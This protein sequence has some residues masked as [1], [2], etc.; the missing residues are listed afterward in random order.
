[1]LSPEL[2][3]LRDLGAV[4]DLAD[5]WPVVNITT[6]P[7]EHARLGIA[8]L[9]AF[10]GIYI[11]AGIAALAWLDATLPPMMPIRLV[12]SPEEL[13]TCSAFARVW[14]DRVTTVIV[15]GANVRKDPVPD[16]LARCVHVQSVHIEFYF[17]PVHTYMNAL[18]TQQL[19]TLEIDDG[20]GH[21]A[22]NASGIIA[23]LQGPHATS[24]SLT[25]NSVRD[26]AALATAIYDCSHLTS[27]L[28]DVITDLITSLAILDDGFDAHLNVSLLR[29]LDRTKVVSFSLEKCQGD[30]GDDVV[31]TSVLDALAMC[32]AL[33]TL[34]LTNLDLT[35]ASR[36]AGF[37][38]QLTTVRVRS[39]DF[40]TPRERAALLKWL[41]TS[42]CLT[43]VD[44]SGT[45]LQKEGIVELARALPAWMARGLETLTLQGAVRTTHA[46]A[47]SKMTKR[48]CQRA[49]RLSSLPGVVLHGLLHMLD[50][51]SDVLILLDALPVVTL[52]P[53]LVALR[54]LGAVVALDE[55]WPVVHVTKIPIEHAH[56]GVAA[57]PAFT[58]VH[59]DSGVASLAWL[60]ATP[61]AP[62]TLVADASVPGA[63]SAFAYAWG[64][65]ITKV[66]VKA[67][68]EDEDEN[69]PVPEMLARCSNVQSVEI[70]SD[71]CISPLL[72][73]MPTTHLHTLVVDA[74]GESDVDTSSIVAWLQGPRATSLSFLAN[75]TLDPRTL[76][77]AIHACPTLTS[78]HVNDALDLLHALIALPKTLDN[79]SS[80]SLC[81]MGYEDNNAP[82]ALKVLRKLNPNNVVSFALQHLSG[83]D[84][85]VER[86]PSF[87]NVLATYP[88]LQALDLNDVFLSNVTTTDV[89]AHLSNVTVCCTTFGT[90]NDAVH[91]IRWLS[92][93]RVLRY[94]DLTRTKLGKAGVDA[95][96][97]A[98]PMWMTSGLETLTLSA[99]GL[100]GDDAAL[101]AGALAAGKNRRHFALD[102]SEN[103]P[104]TL[105]SARR[106]MAALGASHNV[107][108]D[109]GACFR[110][111]DG[112]V[113]D[114]F[115]QVEA[116]LRL[117][118]PY[119]VSSG[120]FKA[121][122]PITSLWH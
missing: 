70:Q 107:T 56:L 82:V 55:H 38:P 10:A 12:V 110:R 53:E 34:S 39:T 60:D 115:V 51:D 91:F 111:S 108:L 42:R 41:S 50:D 95:L 5:H 54:D 62:V 52:P 45:A 67:C 65:R 112:A 87:I 23:W 43:S 16:I 89:C 27:S 21:D 113:C 114:Q 14:G 4:V 24:L 66:I 40:D 58:G 13:G 121:P 33:S 81:E 69:D 86:I 94:V 83:A 15:Q 68:D 79:I 63:L 11:D 29:K 49:T 99:A 96:A 46:P 28:G 2:V 57:L 19:H 80:L 92:T 36:T 118:Q 97:Q 101:L 84:L 44:L 109:L 32:P 30:E 100:N 9:P 3:A 71:R 18:S 77:K 85:Q 98:L 74:L 31:T 61:K 64:D 90:S 17:V 93:S 103:Y 75:T 119:E 72:A 88:S 26:P 25:C 104:L 78:L 8:A 76:A 35:A 20:W 6:M 120:V 1:M 117:H 122:S 47:I 37:W 7:I 59:V 73:A 106:L 116:L 102:L 22:V 48:V 105:A